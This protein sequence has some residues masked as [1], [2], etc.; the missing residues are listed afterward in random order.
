VVADAAIALRQKP[1]TTSFLRY[2]RNT[3][4]FAI[5]P[6]HDAHCHIA[7]CGTDIGFKK[8]WHTGQI[9]DDIKRPAAE[10]QIFLLFFDWVFNYTTRVNDFQ[11][12][13]WG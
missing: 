11:D 3:A 5:T 12:K 10:Y 13:L 8:V 2:C 6:W 7:A 1:R 9:N 4:K